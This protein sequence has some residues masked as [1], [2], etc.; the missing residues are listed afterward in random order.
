MQ[1]VKSDITSSGK[2]LNPVNTKCVIWDGPDI[3][4]LDGTI[5]C[6]GQTI[7][8]T[9]YTL[10]TK[11]CDIYTALSLEDINTCINNINDGTSV[12]IGPTS[13]IKEVFS[14][15][16]KKVC[17]LD[18]RVTELE[19]SPCLEQTAVVPECLRAQAVVYPS[20]DPVTYTLPL[21]YYAELV[22]NS[23]CGILIDITGL[24]NNA[25]IIN[26][27]IADLW[28][29][30]DTCSNATQNTVVPTC[31]YNYNINPN[32]GPV[33]IQTAYSWLEADFCTLRGAVGTTTE[34]TNAV[35]TQ[36][37]NLS[38]EDRL[39][40]SGTM[41]TL[42]G[43]VSNPI[44]I[45]DTLSNLWLT[46]C[47]MR[48]EVARIVD[49]CCFSMCDYLGVGYVATWSTDGTQ[50]TISF[51]DPS[52][53]VVYT[54]GLVPPAA[55]SPFSADGTTPLPAWVTTQFPT[56]SQTNVLFTFSDGSI[57][58]TIDTGD[59]INTWATSGSQ[60]VID[61]TT[62]APPGY[63]QTSLDQQ[64]QI[65]FSYDVVIGTN[66][67]TCTYD[68]LSGLPYICNTP[69]P[70][71]CKGGILTSSTTGTDM[72]IKVTGL[73]QDTANIITS[74]TTGAASANNR[75]KDTTQSFGAGDIGYIVTIT[76]G[77]AA[78]QCRYI[79]SIVS[80]TEVQVD[81]NWDVN[82]TTNTYTVEDIHYSY[83]FTGTG[84]TG[85][86]INVVLNDP[87]FDIN[88][89]STWQSYFS[90]NNIAP[91]TIATGQGYHILDN[92]LVANT[93]YIVLVSATYPCGTSDYATSTQFNQIAGSI[94]IQTGQPGIPAVNIFSTASTQISNVLSNGN[95]LPDSTATITIPKT[96]ALALP[97]TP[98]TTEFTLKPNSATWYVPTT[99]PKV[100]CYCGI[101]TSPTGVIP[102]T[103]TPARDAVLG[104]Y[105][106]YAVEL[107]TQDQNLNYIPILDANNNPYIADSVTDPNITFA[108]NSPTLGGPPP[109]GSPITI[110][111]PYTYSQS[112]YPVVVR[113]DNTQSKYQVNYGNTFHTITF[114]QYAGSINFANPAFLGLNLT[115]T[116][117]AE[118]KYWDQANTTYVSYASSPIRQYSHTE[119]IN[120]PAYGT[121]T[122]NSGLSN[123]VALS[124]GYGDALFLS[125]SIDKYNYGTDFT[126][127]TGHIYIVPSAQ[128]GIQNYSCAGQFNTVG[129][130]MSSP[131]LPPDPS[132]L[133]LTSKAVITEDYDF[134][135]ILNSITIT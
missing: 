135:M 122:F 8:V 109:V 121:Y 68:V 42:S 16:I 26:Q 40:G 47:D 125:V 119:T 35:N 124:A 2:C 52:N 71:A 23:V 51:I 36:C 85:F 22:A 76:D 39:T 88:D 133:V 91:A 45:A 48:T 65:T 90:F 74:T 95:S 89:Q 38:N 130:A 82:P 72:Y 56:A 110:N 64:L 75:L 61:F 27:Q 30:L 96:Y 115:I 66:T 102:G 33:T 20:Y 4:C 92:A 14:A 44:S 46:V 99:T 55:G 100:F 134:S 58:F 77:P 127:A 67:T 86:N 32:G 29:A 10:A 24:Q 17:T 97:N 87:S 78:G 94:R 19:N 28:T 80:S 81:S 18:T 69:M 104:Q 73:V 116:F 21:Q 49:T 43:W 6:K 98:N 126:A 105:R 62:M 12:S 118:I 84:V 131:G 113:Y 25:L 79:T 7:D 111:I 11:L 41:S 57:T 103:T 108:T 107:Y 129:G 5:L 112:T 31:T 132:K 15:I 1:P 70:Y 37:A 83:P 120:L 9:L 93:D 128:P 123:V 117:T 54:S 34:I 59:I 60:I 3:T 101:N 114:T 13:S 50:V 53:P 63:N 106:G